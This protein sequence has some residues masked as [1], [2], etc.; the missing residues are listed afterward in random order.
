MA[1]ILVRAATAGFNSNRIAEMI[2]E[3]GKKKAV[4]TIFSSM[5]HDNGWGDFLAYLAS[6]DSSVQRIKK[7]MAE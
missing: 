1:G 2:R 6:A 5:G 7:E 3:M 4:E